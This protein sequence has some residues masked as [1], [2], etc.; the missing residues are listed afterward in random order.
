VPQFRQS[1]IVMPR[2]RQVLESELPDV[3]AR[4]VDGGTW[5][6]FVEEFRARSPIVFRV[7]STTNSGS[8]LGD[9]R[10]SSTSTLA[11]RRRNHA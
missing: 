9:G 4:L 2:Y 10:W 8:S 1:H 3:F 5:V 7:P 11:L 6:N